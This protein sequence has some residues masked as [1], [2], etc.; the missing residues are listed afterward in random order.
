M[1][2]LVSTRRLLHSSLVVCFRS[3]PPAACS[4]LC[5]I[6]LMMMRRFVP[7]VL[8]L[9]C[10]AAPARAAEPDALYPAIEPFRTGMLK[11]SPP[12]ELY[13]ELSG[14][15]KGRPAIL[16]HG[17]PGSSSS[18]DGRR[19]HN[20]RRWLIV[21]YDQR[22]CGKSRPLRELRDNDTPHLVQDIE[23]LRQHLHLGQVQIVGGS[24]GSTLALA[25]AERYPQNVSSLV[26]RGVYL[27]TAAEDDFFYYGGAGSFFPESFEQA[28]DSLPHPERHDYPQQIVSV[29]QGTDP[30]RRLKVARA[31]TDFE[32]RLARPESTE[33]EVTKA[34]SDKDVETVGLMEAYYIAH[35][36]FL[37][38][39]QLLQDAGQLRAIP[40]VIIQGRLDFVCP[41]IAAYRL[42]QALPGAR[43]V[44]VQ[45]GGHSSRSPDVRAALVATIRS[46]DSAPLIDAR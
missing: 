10:L 33:E 46:F 11:V 16:L 5:Y 31:W 18:P 30:A 6:A 13:Y 4:A 21:Q 38:E 3:S 39:G 43:L 27:A 17:G 14:N 20:P 42:S 8:L 45:R 25:Y 24:W 2:P 34:I 29:L 37:K 28:R 36:C 32:T 19:L 23:A 15:P 7:L 40:T 44:W 22:G 26:L 12:H 9:I 35:H 1:F 41:P